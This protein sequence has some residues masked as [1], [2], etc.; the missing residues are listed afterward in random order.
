M[1]ATNTSDAKVRPYRAFRSVPGAMP[2]EF[3]VR[4]TLI[5]LCVG[6]KPDKCRVHGRLLTTVR[7]RRVMMRRYFAATP[8]I[9][10]TLADDGKLECDLLNATTCR[11]GHLANESTIDRPR[12]HRSAL[13][14]SQVHTGGVARMRQGFPRDRW[15][16]S[17]CVR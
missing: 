2:M 14:C 15:P 5:P 13:S 16:L 8:S 10:R 1:R 3:I 11:P 17:P 6:S 7:A 9:R 4:M 12:L